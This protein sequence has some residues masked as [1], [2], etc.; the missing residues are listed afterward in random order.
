M[1]VTLEMEPVLRLAASFKLDTAVVEYAIM[2]ANKL[3]GNVTLE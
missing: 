1:D 3:S 2:R